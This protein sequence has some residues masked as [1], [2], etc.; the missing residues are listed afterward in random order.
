MNP[1]KEATKLAA[2]V[3]VIPEKY[4]KNK[5]MDL[6]WKK[7]KD[8]AILQMKVKKKSPRYPYALGDQSN[9]FD[10]YTYWKDVP[11]AEED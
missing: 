10:T 2:K 6:R 8:G 4:K 1:I 9:Q 7:T 3:I 11:I 5:D